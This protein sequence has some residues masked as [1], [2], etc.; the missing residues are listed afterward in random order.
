MKQPNSAHCF[1]CG[2]ENEYGLKL[3]FY[4]DGEL[5]VVCE[6][7]ISD[8]YQGFPGIAHG[9]IVTTLLDEALVRAFMTKD[10]NRFMYTAKLTVRFRK[11]VPTEQLLKIEGEVVKDRGRMGESKAKILGPD[12]DILAEAEA[13]VVALE[14]EMQPERRE[15][16]G[17]KV[18]ED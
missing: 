8:Q 1:A 11:Q 18:Y 2:M 4:G 10:P 13:L 12:G 15:E 9:G 3:P 6:Y 17:W 5:R 16:L 7:T 14:E